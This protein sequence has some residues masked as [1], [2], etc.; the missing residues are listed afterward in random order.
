VMPVCVGVVCV[1]MVGSL[2]RW[3][4]G[5]CDL[6]V[7]RW[8]QCAGG[9]VQVTYK[10]RTASGAAVA[11]DVQPLRGGRRPWCAELALGSVAAAA[12]VD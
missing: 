10:A 11:A 7:D 8:G 1:F 3:F 6:L 4:E 5:C 12:V 9:D 2:W